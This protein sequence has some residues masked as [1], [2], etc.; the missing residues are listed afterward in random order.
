M[1]TA[2][3]GKI[4]N[5]RKKE[6]NKTKNKKKED[7]LSCW[8]HFSVNYFEE[9]HLLRLSL[10]IFLHLKFIDEGCMSPKGTYANNEI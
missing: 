9:K 10:C 2:R 5:N 3:T 6:K 7:F 4:R 1:E 8:I